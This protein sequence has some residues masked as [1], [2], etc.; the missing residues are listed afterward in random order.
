MTPYDIAVDA[1]CPPHIL[2][3]L[4]RA[5]PDYRSHERRRLNYE[6]RREAMFL[7]FA[8]V[9]SDC[10]RGDEVVRGQQG[11]VQVLVQ[12]EIQGHSQARAQSFTVVECLRNLAAVGEDMPLLRH[13]IAYL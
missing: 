1:E 12:A 7:A 13:L 6:A 9:R 4:L 8:A 2:R 10:D 11:E 5:A 3:L